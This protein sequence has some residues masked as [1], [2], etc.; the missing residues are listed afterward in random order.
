MWQ[1]L[2]VR[3]DCR[4][5]RDKQQAATVRQ[6]VQVGSKSL[7]VGVGEAENKGGAAGRPSVGR[8]LWIKGATVDFLEV[9]GT[10]TSLET[11]K[12]P[13]FGGVG[14]AAQPMRAEVARDPGP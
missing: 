11:P 13:L 3:P 10:A 2:I 14:A 5:R 1:M 4:Q 6:S 7:G 8:R 12:T 9:V